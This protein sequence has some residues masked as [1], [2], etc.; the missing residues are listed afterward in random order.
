MPNSFCLVN[1]L[2]LL[3]WSWK[4][5]GSGTH[6]RPGVFTSI[7][8]GSTLESP[9]VLSSANSCDWVSA[10]LV[11]TR[12]SLPGPLDH[13]RKMDVPGLPR[14]PPAR[15]AMSS[16][17]LCFG[18]SPHTLKVVHPEPPP[19]AGKGCTWWLKPTPKPALEVLIPVGLFLCDSV[20]P[21]TVAFQ[22]HL[23]MGFSRQEYRSGLQFPAGDLHDPGINW[24]GL[25]CVSCIDRQILCHSATWE[26]P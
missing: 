22:A 12:P 2:G 15:A 21:W 20:T 6:R 14:L 23:S 11:S 3:S 18:E 5:A 10:G 26:A 13:H 25:P 1:S 24:T 7:S 16:S 8:A 4:G 9:P 17:G 19:P